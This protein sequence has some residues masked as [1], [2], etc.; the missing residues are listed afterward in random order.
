MVPVKQSGYKQKVEVL[1]ERADTGI[2]LSLVPDRGSV[3]IIFMPR[4][5]QLGTILTNK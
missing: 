5:Q 2:H 1:A 4:A 3:F